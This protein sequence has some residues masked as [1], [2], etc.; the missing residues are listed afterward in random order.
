MNNTSLLSKMSLEE[1][2]GQMFLLAFAGKRLEEARIMLQ[3]HYVGGCYISQENAAT[4]EEALKLS[5]TLQNFATDTPHGI[6]LLLGA[7]Q[8]GTWGVLVPYS[9]TGPG[10]LAL[11][12]T[13]NPEMTRQMY[14]VIGQ[15]LTAVGYN[16]VF[17]PCADVNSNPSNPIIGMHVVI[18]LVDIMDSDPHDSSFKQ[19]FSE[20]HGPLVK[21]NVERAWRYHFSHAHT[22]TSRRAASNHAH[23]QLAIA[24]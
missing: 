14:Q 17:A 21:L 23:E 22:N 18:V 6:P 11:G 9:S 2:V 13:Q 4:P 20:C 15:E 3:K 19:N 1:K 12:A 10:N 8:E 16:A 24:F 7:D 5:T